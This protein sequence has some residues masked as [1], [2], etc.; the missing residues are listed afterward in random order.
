MTDDQYEKT[1]RSMCGTVNKS[2]EVKLLQE[3]VREKGLIEWLQEYNGR[4]SIRQVLQEFSAQKKALQEKPLKDITREETTAI[5]LRWILDKLPAQRS[6]TIR[7]QDSDGTVFEVQ[8]RNHKR[9]IYVNDVRQL[10]KTRR[11][12]NW[13]KNVTYDNLTVEKIERSIRTADKLNKRKKQMKT[14]RY[15]Q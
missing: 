8:M 6:V 2:D 11:L 4:R 12:Y 7:L 3:R 14:K 13:K 1:E 15:A 9:R 5:I 10:K